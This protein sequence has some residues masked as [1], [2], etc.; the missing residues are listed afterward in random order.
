[1]SHSF[2]NVVIA[3]FPNPPPA[4]AFDETDGSDDEQLKFSATVSKKQQIS[5]SAETLKIEYKGDNFSHESL[6]NDVSR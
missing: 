4:S 1:M 2:V 5:I 3:H 6:V